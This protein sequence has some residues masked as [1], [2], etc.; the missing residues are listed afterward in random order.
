LKRHPEAAVAFFLTAAIF[1]MSALFGRFD[2]APD[3]HQH[4][5]GEYYNIARAIVDGRGFSD[6]FGER[7]GPTAWMP[8]VYPLILAAILYVAKTRAGTAAVVLVMT[9]LAYVAMGT[10]VFA[11]ARRQS[12]RTPP[13]VAVGIYLLW[14]A[15]F[16]SWTL[17]LTHDV[18][19]VALAANALMIVVWRYA[20]ARTMNRWTWLGVG[21]LG[22]LLALTSPALALAW[23]VIGAFFA[24]TVKPDR[25]KWLGAMAIAV[26]LAAPWAIRNAVVFHRFVLVKSNLFFDAYQGSYVARDGVYDIRTMAQHPLVSPLLRFHYA[27]AGESAY[28]DGYRADFLRS[29]RAEPGRFLRAVGQRAAAATLV[30]PPLEAGSETDAELAVHRAVYPVPFLAFFVSAW[31]RGPNRRL[32]RLLGG[33]AALHMAPYVLLAFYVRYT[34]PLAPVFALIVF[35]AIEQVAYRTA[36][37]R[38]TASRTRWLEARPRPVSGG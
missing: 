31:I 22:G 30:Y 23:S 8:P 12:G 2:R 26:A 11:I 9:D 20:A 15:V 35:L 25:R 7:T 6:P 18:W 1:A 5:G 32:L 29:L 13:V 21:I 14:I 38:T 27:R 3:F 33:L 34:A 28:V 16:H 10:T 4:L 17:V 19:V 24:F 37:C 36:H